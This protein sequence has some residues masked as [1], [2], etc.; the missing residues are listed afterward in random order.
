M[1]KRKEILLVLILL[2][3][4]LH[5]TVPLEIGGS[6]ENVT[7]ASQQQASLQKMLQDT[8]HDRYRDN[9]TAFFLKLYG[10]YGGFGNRGG[11]PWDDLDRVFEKHDYRYGVHGFL[12]AKSDARLLEE[13]PF[14]LFHKNIHKE[15]YIIGPAVFVFFAT[16]LPSVY[17][18]K[19]FG[20]DRVIPIF[21]P[22]GSCALCTYKMEQTLKF[23]NNSNTMDKALDRMKKERE[24]MHENVHDWLD[25]QNK[26]RKKIFKNFF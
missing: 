22:N 5:G 7:R 14:V 3:S 4:L 23:L 9:G 15:G 24:E 13:L 6:E 18:V 12:D 26:K 21:M 11:K 8:L 2:S 25:D 1:R 19:I 20:K 16:A 10:N 17:R